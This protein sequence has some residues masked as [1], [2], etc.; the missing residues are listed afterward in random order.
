MNVQSHVF[1][2]L[3]IIDRIRDYEKIKGFSQSYWNIWM[4]RLKKKNKK[5]D[6]LLSKL[7]T[8]SEQNQIILYEF[9]LHRS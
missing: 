4:N 3:F 7:H 5:I 6:K 1:K 2:F 8:I 9:I